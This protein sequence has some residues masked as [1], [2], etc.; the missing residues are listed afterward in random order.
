[1]CP[2]RGLVI[3][4]SYSVREGEDPLVVVCSPLVACE[5]LRRKGAAYILFHD[6]P[7]IGAE[8]D[9]S[10]ELNNNVSLMKAAPKWTIISSATLP[11]EEA[12]QPFTS[13][14]KNRYR[15]ATHTSVYS[16]STS[17]GCDIYS[18]DGVT[19]L[20]HLGLRSQQG[21]KNCLEYI[22][23]N[24]FLSRAYTPLSVA[25]LSKLCTGKVDIVDI[26][27]HFCNI[28][29]LSANAVRLYGLQILDKLTLQ[30]DNDIESVCSE[31]IKSNARTINFSK[32]GTTEAYKLPQMSLLASDNPVMFTLEHFKD[33]LDEVKSSKYTIEKLLGQYYQVLNQWNSEIENVKKRKTK[34]SSNK[35]RSSKKRDDR[36][37]DGG[38][39]EPDYVQIELD[40][41]ANRPFL[42]FPEAFQINT[43]QH[44]IKYGPG[45]Q[46]DSPRFPISNFGF[47]EDIGMNVANDFKLLLCCGVGIYAPECDQVKND[48]YLS[49]VIVTT[50]AC[51]S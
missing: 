16:N 47:I 31:P 19:Y 48:Q 34:S 51:N 46:F 9:G 42:T 23:N 49:Y 12:L 17:M 35:S 22:T 50:F 36:E 45:T 28:E 20:P 24:M 32:L 4:N 13:A 38:R 3:R 26:N 30:N 15:D 14:H 37:R 43:I 21:L 5:V 44:Y 40:L 10:T 6:E 39:E 29:N 7:T 1:M 41:L 2:D 33:L 27:S 8:E 11:S 18:L 25:E